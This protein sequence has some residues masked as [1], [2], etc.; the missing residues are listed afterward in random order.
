MVYEGV[1]VRSGEVDRGRSRST[2]IARVFGALLG[3]PDGFGSSDFV[4]IEICLCSIDLY[5]FR[6]PMLLKVLIC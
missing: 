5:G 3:R 1:G 4:G 2:D 6:K